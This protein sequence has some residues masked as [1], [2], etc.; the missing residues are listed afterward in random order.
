MSKLT[1]TFGRRH[2]ET[3]SMADRLRCGVTTGNMQRGHAATAAPP[4]SHGLLKGQAFAGPAH[5]PDATLLCLCQEIWVSYKNVLS[6]SEI[7]SLRCEEY[8]SYTIIAG[9]DYWC[10]FQSLPR[11]SHSFSKAFLTCFQRFFRLKFQHYSV[12]Q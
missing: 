12:V 4:E 2:S 6:C 3:F 9:C 1:K 5:G 7:H 11:L 8:I 10:S